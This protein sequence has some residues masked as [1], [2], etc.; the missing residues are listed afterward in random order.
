MGV[1]TALFVGDVCNEG[2][3][4]AASAALQSIRGG[5]S[6][7]VSFHTTSGHCSAP[8]PRMA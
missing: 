3:S 6:V 2:F 8:W 1:F 4:G 7:N 5:K